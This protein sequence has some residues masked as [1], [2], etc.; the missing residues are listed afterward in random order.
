MKSISIELSEKSIEKAIAEIEAYKN[1]YA[2]KM[3]EFLERLADAGIAVIDQNMNTEGDSS[4]EHYAYVRINSFGS[5]SEATIVL[6]GQDVGFIE[7]GAGI[8]YNG[9][10]GTSPHPKGQEMQLTIGSYGK[11]NGAKDFWWYI[12]ETGAPRYSQ[13][14]KAS[15]PM[16]KAGV[17]IRERVFQ[18]AKEVF[19]G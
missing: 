7:F 15:M 4:P 17:E 9:A 18:I 19:G 2:Y 10:S 13:G 11:G 16:Y 14:T 8:H 12:D 5:Y 1:S 3:A 6:Q